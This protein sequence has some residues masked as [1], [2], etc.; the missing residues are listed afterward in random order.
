M[1]S[2]K[3]TVGILLFDM[4]EVLDFSGPFEVFSRTRTEPGTASRRSDEKAPFIVRTV[5]KA[6]QVTAT[7]G[8]KLQAEWTFDSLP[9][10]VDILVIPGGYGT[11]PLLEDKETIDW[12]RSSAEKASLVTS[13]CTGALLLAKAG[14][15]KD[16]K[17]T[18]HWASLDILEQIEPS[19][20]VDRKLRWVEDGNV[21]TSAGVAAGIDMSFHVVER[22]CGKEIADE[23]AHYIEYP[24][25]LA[26]DP[27]S[28]T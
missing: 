5:A 17:V 19:A 25:R 22:V 11:R 20:S 24:R 18:S 16:K 7:G 23:T 28:S 12:I 6:P 2:K 4:V 14:W 10:P 26:T 27:R 9:A 3:K 8:L 1:T 15:L 13:V 21:I